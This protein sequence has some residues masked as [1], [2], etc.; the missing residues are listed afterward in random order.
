MDNK[1]QICH[2]CQTSIQQCDSLGPNRRSLINS[3]VFLKG[4]IVYGEFPYCAN[5]NCNESSPHFI[6][7]L[8]DVACV[9]GINLSHSGTYPIT[10]N[11][12][13]GLP[14][15]THCFEKKSDVYIEKINPPENYQRSKEQKQALASQL[16]ILV[17][18]LLL[19][20]SHIIRKQKLNY[21]RFEIN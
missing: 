21:I 20:Y 5:Y 6:T 14:L 12:A 13:L 18:I 3:R 8:E 17:K 19:D 2:L 15:I 7:I 16:I 1:L 4:C 11:L 9:L 10:L